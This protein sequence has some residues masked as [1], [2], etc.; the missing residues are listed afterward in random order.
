MDLPSPP[1][2]ACRLSQLACILSAAVASNNENLEELQNK[3]NELPLWPSRSVH[4]RC[5]SC[6]SIGVFIVILSLSI[7]CIGVI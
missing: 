2:S 1:K 7:L 6:D 5:G 3:E 4:Q